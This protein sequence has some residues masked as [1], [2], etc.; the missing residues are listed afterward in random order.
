M[1]LEV[2]MSKLKTSAQQS[3]RPVDAATRDIDQLFARSRALAPSIIEH[4]GVFNTSSDEWFTVFTTLG[5]PV[6]DRVYERYDKID[7]Q[8]SDAI[9]EATSEAR[10]SGY[11]LGLAVGLRLAKGQIGG[12][13]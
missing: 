4:S 1:Q 11:A 10:E 3:R 13:R 2:S 8:L 7:A 9:S 6:E 12:A 5:S